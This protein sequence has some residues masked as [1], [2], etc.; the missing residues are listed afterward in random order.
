MNKWKISFW[1]CLI[2]LI[3]VTAF[4]IYA[5]FEQAVTLN[6]QKEGYDETEKDLEIL[7]EIISK[8]DL[9]KKQ[10]EIDLK[11]NKLLE[12]M[13]FQKDTISLSRISFVFENNKLKSI[14]KQW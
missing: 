4:T 5:I 14:I 3:C 7:I 11:D 8:T 6:Y 9:T 2:V 12:N 13:D 10:I 1:F